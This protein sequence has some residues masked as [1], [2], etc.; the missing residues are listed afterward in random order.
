MRALEAVEVTLT[1]PERPK[2]ID[3]RYPANFK[4]G[5]L[6]A[7]F[8]QLKKRTK[9]TVAFSATGKPFPPGPFNVSHV[10]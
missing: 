3:N 8:Y 7:G 6:A 9:Y 5:L 10:E 2:P 1:S 4:V